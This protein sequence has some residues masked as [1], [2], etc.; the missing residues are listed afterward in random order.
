MKK[1]VIIWIW[2]L[3]PLG[4]MAAERSVGEAV[5][6]AAEFMNEQVARSPK[7]NGAGEVSSFALS[8]T[9]SKLN[10]E[11][12]AYYVLNQTDGQGFAVVSADDRTEDV[13]MYS[14]EGSLDMETANPNLL[15]WLKYLQEQISAADDENGYS[16]EEKR[17]RK[18]TNVTAISP[19]LVTKKGANILWD[20]EKPYY[21]QCPK[22]SGSYCMTGCVATATAQVMCMWQHPVKGKGSHSYTTQSYKI[23]VEQDFSAVTFDW[24]NMLGTYKSV[25][26]TTDQQNAVAWLMRCC[27]V[28]CDMDYSPDGSGSYTD[29][30]AYGLMTYFDYTFDKFVTMYSRAGYGT[31]AIPTNKCQF[32][33]KTEDFVTYFNKDLEAGRPIIM[34]GE[35]GPDGGH[36]FVC[37]GRD[38]SGNFHINWGWNGSSNCYCALTALK[39]KSTS[40]DFST[41]IDALIGLRPNAVDTVHVTGVSIVPEVDTLKINQKDTLKAVVAPD[42]ATNKNVTWQSEDASIAFVSS[43]GVVRGVAPGTTTITATTEDGHKTAQATIVVS[44]EV[45]PLSLFKMLTDTNQ[46]EVGDDVILVAYYNSVYYAMDNVIHTTTSTYYFSTEVQTMDEDSTILLPDNSKTAIFNLGDSA[47]YWTLSESTYGKLGCKKAKMLTWNMGVQTWTIALNSL[48]LAVVESR[49]VNFGNIR[50]NY[51]NGTPRFTTY[52]GVSADYIVPML[53]IRKKEHPTKIEPVQKEEGG[54]SLGTKVMIDGGLYI[55]RDGRLYTILG[56][57][58]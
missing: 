30:M 56:Q 25:S 52:M 24:N 49:N 32:S 2:V 11:V 48:N 4:M 38:A 17:A 44:K 50:Y 55:L 7:R 13:L 16:S 57:E 35:D 36:E 15:F 46:L 31:P 34:G 39:P 8:H 10:S 21:N 5:R 23:K 45:E 40:Y 26:A 20:Q 22:Y 51:N 33:A 28:A 53:F 12:P 54:R 18:A 41:N 29:R 47:G 14:E 27:G 37:D 42:N 9:C 58:R 6:L 3:M 19:L 1:R 43:E